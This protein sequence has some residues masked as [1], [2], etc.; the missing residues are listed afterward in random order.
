MF[1]IVVH[2]RQWA[3]FAANGEFWRLDETSFAAAPQKC[4]L[5]SIKI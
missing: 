5:V 4:R 3:N 1:L 2:E